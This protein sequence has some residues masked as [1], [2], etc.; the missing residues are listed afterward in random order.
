MNIIIHEL[1]A[2]IKAFFLWTIGLAFLIIGGMTKYSG[3]SAASGGNITALLDQFPKI[4]LA[5]F[6]MANVDIRMLGG[7]YSVLE[8]FTLVCVG[9]YA[10]QL[11]INSVSRERIDKTYEF[12]FT[13]PRTRAF[14]LTAKLTAGLI[15][16]VFI[17]LMSTLLSYAALFIHS[18]DN[19]ISAVILLYA[20]ASLLIGL[21]F[22]SLSAMLAAALSK[23]ESGAKTA[24]AVFL[25]TYIVW[26]VYNSLDSA[27][28]LKPFAPLAYFEAGEV[29]SGSLN[30]A[31]AAVCLI[32]AAILLASA[33]RAFNKRDLSAV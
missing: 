2:G 11:G 24:Y 32:G 19:T 3:A 26:V 6:G 8:N 33:Y 14:I 28:P 5:M 1:K 30:I 29:I 31:Y 17:C 15:F 10:I 25:V 13:K 9:I 23:A 21:L 4:F 20:A 18:I 12:V 27:A 22:F 16:L 7:F